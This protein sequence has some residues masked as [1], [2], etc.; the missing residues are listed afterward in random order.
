MEENMKLYRGN[1]L[2]RVRIVMWIAGILNIPIKIM[3]HN[4]YT[5]EDDIND[6]DG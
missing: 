6:G 2:W 4:Y 1:P 5:E 3:P